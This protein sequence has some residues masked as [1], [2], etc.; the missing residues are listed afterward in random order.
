MRRVDRELCISSIQKMGRFRAS[1]LKALPEILEDGD[2]EL[3]D[4][5]RPTRSLKGAGKFTQIDKIEQV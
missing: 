5:Y 4:F 3:P 2:N 1:A